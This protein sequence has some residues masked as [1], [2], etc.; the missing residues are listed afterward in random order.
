MTST[1]WFVVLVLLE[2]GGNT[3]PASR[4]ETGPGGTTT[5][6][7]AWRVVKLSDVLAGPVL[8]GPDVGALPLVPLMKFSDPPAVVVQRVKDRI[9][10][11]APANERENLLAVAQVLTT[12]RFTDQALIA[13][14]G[15]KQRMM[16]SPLVQEIVDEQRQQTAH[17]M[18]LV[19]LDQR[20]GSVPV[21]VSAAVRLTT[22]KSAL[23]A[24]MR[25]ACSCPDLA[26]FRTH[27]GL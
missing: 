15:G 25:L 22:E 9:E 17:E 24:L 26:A 2:R 7:G 18:I 21:E 4:Q 23:D 8:A 11:E 5:L 3:V 6:G 1:G 19:A 12:A 16:I 27:L 10:A 14:L 20:F 13:I